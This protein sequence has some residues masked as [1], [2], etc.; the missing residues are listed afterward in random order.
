MNGFFKP[1][2]VPLVLGHRGCPKL[3]QENTLAG[4]RA[5]CTQGAAGIELDVFKT[6]DDRIVVFHDDDIKRL[7]GQP[8]NI[9]ELTWDEISKLSIKKSIDRGDGTLIHYQHEQPIPL[10]EEVIDELPSDFLINIEMKAYS[11]NWFKRSTGKL[12]ADIIK[13]TQS[14]NQVVVTSFDFF[15]LNALE[16][17]CPEIHSGF[18]YDDSMLGGL[19]KW[20]NQ[21]PI[22]ELKEPTPQDLSNSHWLLNFLLELNSVGEFV[23]STVADA[24]HNLIDD[25]TASKY[26]DNNMLL[27][28]YTLFPEDTRYQASSKID[29]EHEAL[30][31]KSAGV[32][33]IETDDP[34]RLLEILNS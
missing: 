21:L 11:P 29:H 3:Y 16:N 8:G 10:L 32:D 27:G 5:A 19:A 20:I 17:Q 4:F 26:H 22:P 28:A 1:K 12:V 31:L 2:A 18:A 6:A 15:M 25:D 9:S 7:T 33:W 34:G 13:K 24:E 14:Q 23:H 30:R